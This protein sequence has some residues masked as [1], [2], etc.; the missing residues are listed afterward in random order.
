MPSIAMPSQPQGTGVGEKDVYD[1]R[2]RGDTPGVAANMS[3]TPAKLLR[4][5]IKHQGQVGGDAPRC[6]DLRAVAEQG[7]VV[8]ATGNLVHVPVVEFEGEG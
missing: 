7:G 8:E 3:W 6:E 1:N 5:V 4:Y 2:S